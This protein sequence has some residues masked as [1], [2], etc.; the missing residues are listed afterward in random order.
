[1]K[2]TKKFLVGLLCV[3][4][5][6]AFASCEEEHVHSYTDEVTAPTCTEKGY[7]T[8]TC[9]C[10]DTV[11][12]T[13]VDELG[14]D[15]KEYFSDNNATYDSDGTKT[16]TCERENCEEKDTVTEEN[17]KLVSKIAFKSL[18]AN[19]LQVTSAQSF[20][21]ATTEFSFA[22]EI[23]CLGNVSYEVARDQYGENTFL[24]KVVPL[25]EGDNTFYVFESVDGKTNVYQIT[26]RRR[27][28]YTVAFN[29]NGGSIVQNQTV[30]ES[31]FA[32]APTQTTT[33]AGYDFA[34]WNYDFSQAITGNITI[35]AQW[36]AHTDTAYKVEYYF[37]DLQGQYVLDNAKTQNKTGKT[38]TTASVTAETV[39]GFTYDEW[40]SKP[41][42]N[43]NGDGSL[44]LKLYYSR[45]RY[46]VR[47]Q[48]ENGYTIGYSEV[49]YQEE[50]MI[51]ATPDLGYTF[52]GWYNGETLI[53]DKSSYTL[54]MP[55][56]NL[57][58]TA[59][60]EV[61]EEMQNFE[62][63][64]TATTC[65]ITGIKDN[66]I[67]E[68]V[69][70]DYI[71][72]IGYSAFNYCRSLM[73]VVIGDGVK[74]IGDNAFE[75]CSGLTSVVIGDNV[76]SIGGYAFRCCSRLTSIIIPDSVTD[77]GDAA[78]TACRSL[79]SVAIG[80]SV[81][82]IG[83]HAFDG[84][85]K[86]VEVVNRSTYITLEKGSMAGGYVSAYALAVYNSGDTFVSKLSTDNGYIVYTDGEEKI[87][88]GYTGTETHLTLPSYITKIN[89][90]AFY[91]CSS[92]TSIEIPDSVTSIG[93]EAFYRC[94][95][96]TSIEIPDSVTSI[97][98][99]AFSGCYSLTIYCEA[100][101]KPSGWSKEWNYYGY[102]VVW[103][104]KA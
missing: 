73:R 59:K 3:L 89:Q 8:H 62:F 90:Y 23:E 97:G 52:L 18:M 37:Q 55:A 35:N 104:Y 10:G 74:N 45:N 67:T 27:P 103:G 102:P 9:S 30:E 38:D 92:L 33:R 31:Y 75:N 71:T 94:S 79:T 54:T 16:A 1:M 34:G 44:A 32:T 26:L 87:L 20:S 77:I 83:F 72:S 5:V 85:Y 60:W 49:Y 56:E 14:H 96:L 7:T 101:S 29:E 17:T 22:N 15:F 99:Y 58:Y 43:I 98:S 2:K 100:E 70:P 12:D 68:V 64:S 48:E 61:A 41:S 40:Q 80:D 69:I 13:Y 53:S 91:E 84:C 95:S 76:K 57:V 11:V 82:S 51:T 66:T 88:V 63:S 6:C 39:T 24:T 21:N 36:T 46:S 47:C 4:S 78:F 50:K 93:Y 19:G 81:T 42:G 86:L 28:M 65:S 25:N